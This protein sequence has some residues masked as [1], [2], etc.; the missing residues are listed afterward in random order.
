MHNFECHKS[1][2]MGRESPDKNFSEKYVLPFALI[3]DKAIK[4]MDYGIWG[5]KIP[6]TILSRS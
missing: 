5:K 1:T 6:R 3:S 2:G 4:N